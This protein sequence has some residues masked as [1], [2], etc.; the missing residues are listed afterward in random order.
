MKDKQIVAAFDFD[1]T[2]TTKDT[3]VEFIR[4]AKGTSSFLCG[5]L[6]FSPLLIAYKLKLYPNWKVKQHLFSFFFKGMNLHDFEQYCRAFCRQSMHLIRSQAISSI[7]K[8]I[9]KGDSVVIIS[10]SIE[11]WVRPFA[12]CLGISS[13]LCTQLEIDQESCLTGR[14]ASANCYGAEKVRRLLQLYPHREG[15]YLVAYGDSKGDKELLN[16]ADEEYYRKF[17]IH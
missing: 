8:H 2:I 10:A 5:F 17:Q 11:N 9:E 15:Y 13:T 7:Q 12:E 3:F 6:L 1:G 16:F 4:F 14:F